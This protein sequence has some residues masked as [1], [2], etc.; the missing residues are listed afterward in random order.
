MPGTHIQFIT[1]VDALKE[2][3]KLGQVVF[4]YHGSDGLAKRVLL[5]QRHGPRLA[6]AIVLGAITLI[7]R[8]CLGDAAGAAGNSGCGVCCGLT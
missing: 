1:Q 3:G 6:A 4:F 8:V 2:V 7:R 5:K